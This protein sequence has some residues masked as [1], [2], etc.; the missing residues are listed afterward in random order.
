[1][2][3][4]GFFKY[5]KIA[6]TSISKP[7]TQSS[8]RAKV[9][10]EA[11]IGGK[12]FGPVPAHIKREFFYLGRTQ[13]HTVWVWH[14]RIKNTRGSENILTTRYEVFADKVIKSQNNLPHELVAGAELKHL[15]QAIATYGKHVPKQVYGYGPARVSTV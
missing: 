6:K 11:Q 5:F 14:E 13:D 3:P 8:L 9:H 10:A 7:N 15:Y 4:L 1:M 2:N 12:L